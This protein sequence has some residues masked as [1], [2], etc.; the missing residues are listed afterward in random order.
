MT[1]VPVQWHFHSGMHHTRNSKVGSEN[2][3]NR[4]HYPLELHIVHLQTNKTQIKQFRASV[5][6]VM[7]ELSKTS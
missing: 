1:F 5:V 6:A 2:V 4:K 7:F 3:I